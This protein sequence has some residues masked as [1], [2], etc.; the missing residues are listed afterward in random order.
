[1]LKRYFLFIIFTLSVT[2]SF[3]DNWF[4]R[5]LG[6]LG[7]T[8]TTYIEPQHYPSTL[9]LQNSYVFDRISLKDGADELVF[10][11]DVSVQLGPFAGYKFIFLGYTVDLKSFFK[12]KDRTNIAMTFFTNPFIIDIFY[13][14][15]G[16][17]FILRKITIDGLKNMEGMECTAIRTRNV[18]VSF[19]YILN[20]KHYSAPAAFAQTTNQRRNAGSLILGAGVMR[21]KFDLNIT[22]LVTDM[23]IKSISDGTFNEESLDNTDTDTSADS[24]DDM[25]VTRNARFNTF[26]LSAGYGYNWVFARN[27]LVGAAAIVSPGLKTCDAHFEDL[28]E[29]IN[30]VITN[31]SGSSSYVPVESYHHTGV[32]LDFKVHLGVTYNNTRWYCGASASVY[33]NHYNAHDYHLRNTYG[34]VNLY[35]GFYFGKR[36]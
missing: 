12:S 3:A 35:A 15:A 29:T 11:P 14:K 4:T 24:D 9:M 31:H 21:S 25:L 1:M 20:H 8:D 16:N 30:N 27:W 33:D 17:D 13:R 26:S 10:A 2:G 34:S 18:G 19:S 22:D 32:N 5:F 36:N 28:N 23:L 6:K 7:E